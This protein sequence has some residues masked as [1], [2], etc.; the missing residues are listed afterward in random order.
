[1]SARSQRHIT[2]ARLP[3]IPADEL[4]THMSDP[5]VAEHM[6]LLNFT[7][8]RDAIKK[9]VASKEACWHRDG[10]GHWAFLSAGRYVGWGGFQKE[11]EEWEFGLVLRPD[12]FGLGTWITRKALAFAAADARIPFVTFLLPPSRRNLGALKRLGARFI[13]KTDH[14]GAGFLK[15]RLDTPAPP[16]FHPL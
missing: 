6:P 8:D 3:E 11:G 13:G 7:W 5:R 10:L 12:A 15:Y 2:F 14:E 1:M 4:M 16:A 9:F